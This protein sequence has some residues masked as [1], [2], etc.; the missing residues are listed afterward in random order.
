M[1]QI[2]RFLV[3]VL[4]ILSIG[5]AFPHWFRLDSIAAERG[6]QAVGLVG[7]ANLR[8]DVGGIFIAIGVL[9]LI[10]AW[11]RNR[12]WLAATLAVVCS[13]LIGRFAS[14]ALDGAGSGIVEPIAIEAVVVAILVG[15]WKSWGNDVLA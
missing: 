15:A 6:L 9:A 2:F 12:M 5:T 13:A 8:A 3:G 14:L 1:K 4:G 11:S 10:A 7:R